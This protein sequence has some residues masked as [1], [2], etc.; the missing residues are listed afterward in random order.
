MLLPHDPS[1][2]PPILSPLAEARRWAVRLV[3]FLS[4]IALIC[5]ARAHH[6]YRGLEILLGA[7]L[8]F[9][10]LAD[11][12]LDILRGVAARDVKARKLEGD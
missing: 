5:A 12:A 1:N 10:G 11:L 7:V 8:V 3:L 6:H 4:G 9:T 2:R